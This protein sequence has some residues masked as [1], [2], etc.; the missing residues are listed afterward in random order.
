MP[1]WTVP[2]QNAIDARGSN[3]LVSA[4]AGSGKTA[5]LVQRVVNLITDK[6]NPVD[7]DKLLVVTFT[8]AA[9]AEMR[10][11]ISKALNK[12]IANDPQNKNALHQLSLLPSAKI[13]T[14]DSFCINLV[15][16]N[17]FK[18][19]IEQDFKILDESE[20]LVVEQEAMENVIENLYDSKNAIFLSLVEM[21]SSTKND[22][23]LTGAISTISNFIVSQEFPN[24]WLDKILEAYNPAVSLED[25]EACAYVLNEV[26]MLTEYAIILINEA[27]SD[28][29]ID[30][31]LYDKYFAML[32]ADLK[33]FQDLYELAF[34]KKWNELVEKCQAVSFDRTPS[35]KNYTSPS[36]ALIAKNKDTYK[37]I[38]NSSVKPI[39]SLSAEEYKADCEY[40]YPRLKL[41]FDIVKE[42]NKKL[43]ELK[44]D[45]N[46]YTFGDLEHFAIELL[47]YLD[48]NG[49]PKRTELA[50]ELEDS[51]YE[52]LVDEY[53]D[54]NSAQDKLFYMLSNGK[55]RF[56]VGDVK[57]SIYK[58]RLAMPFIFNEKKDSYEAYDEQSSAQSKKIILGTNFRSRQGIC[59]F[60]NFVFSHLMS[61]KVGELDYNWEESLNF[62][63]IDY[64]PTS[65]PCA[66][67]A[68]VNTP[69]SED[70]DEYEAHQIANLILQKI[71][72]KEQIRDKD[73]HDNVFYRDIRFGDFA[74]LFRAPKNRMP[75]F[76]KVFSSYGIPTVSNNK[77]NLFEN[78]EITILLNLIRVV[79][80]PTLDIP[81]LATLMSVFYGFT[82]DQIA[83]ARVQMPKSSLYTAVSKCDDFKGFFDD[84]SRY[85]SFA[86]SMS[87]ES[88]IRTI[89]SETSYLSVISALGNHEQRVQNVLRFVDLAKKF[90]NGESIGLTAFVRYID[91]VIK[92][93][94]DIPSASVNHAGANAVALMSVHQSKGLEFPVVILA[95]S[96][97]KYNNDD[98]KN[99]LQL[100]AQAGIGV[101]VY[102]DELMYR[103]DSLQ[104]S[105]IADK[106]KYASMS[107]NLRVLYVAITRAKEQFITVYSHKTFES[108][109]SKLASKINGKS[110]SPFV[111]KSVQCDGDMILLCSLLHKDANC[112][113]D[114]CCDDIEVDASF[115][116]DYD[117]KVL[118]FGATENDDEILTASPKAEEIRA[119]EEKLSF[120]YER[121]SLSSF[122]SKRTA[123][124]LDDE[125]Q[126]FE[127]LTSSKPAFLNKSKMT[128]AQKGT[129]MHA[130]MQYCDYQNTRESLESE[131]ERLVAN[132][133]ITKEQADS[134]DRARL[135][136]LFNSDFAN[137]MFNSDNI[138]R[139][140]K[141]T[142]YMPVN[143]LE[144]TKFDDKV[145]VQGIADCV[146]EENGELVLVDYKTDR[147][148]NEQE[149]LER[150]KKQVSFY[151]YAVAKVLQKPVKESILY[152]F[153]LNKPCI[154]K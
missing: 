17:F 153:A 71:A 114:M 14:I 2:Q 21:L 96:C 89:I 39:L 108:H 6:Q 84:I 55:N 11:R 100:N 124:S 83:Q 120:C 10:T 49:E 66:S 58:F 81:L 72:N 86:S 76:N 26:A 73:E 82:T 113:R 7:V 1:K 146:F 126:S 107:E 62:G 60:T 143:M 43:L 44:R 67:L 5:V 147:V 104:F 53:Q 74:I 68:V 51:Y 65:I 133:F 70:V 130:F 46:S 31:E 40:L 59:D 152:S 134:L 36:K 102:N 27:L 47:F 48:E 129:A 121:K 119:I 110:I 63:A 50:Q 3:I 15:R 138:Y 35:K 38:L 123:S 94:F 12:I 117:I 148:E 142:S 150:Y 23:A 139:E 140:I 95:S 112:L 127:Y 149:L 28:L 88:F 135:M 122:A 18:L 20:R 54:T 8:N 99:I 87:V 77:T 132:S 75:V 154:Y 13:C 25:S 97:H 131:I 80:N 33:S 93:Q 78:S 52:I 103:Y 37:T 45:L 111:V 34:N 85:R 9:A 4:A 79:D 115:D 145:L 22:N 64:A 69:E 105:V 42:Y 106:N 151:K 92:N 141:V 19:D 32:N 90:D 29:S 91:A 136:A 118:D 56:M 125:E 16:E 109:L 98:Q 101:K 30:D 137:R 128:S 57:Q 61:K 41:L 24:H 144:D 116:F